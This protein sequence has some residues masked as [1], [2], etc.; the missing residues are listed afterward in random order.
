MTDLHDVL[1]APE[2]AE[3]LRVH[4]KTVYKLAKDGIIPGKLFGRSWRFSRTEILAFVGKGM[5]ESTP[6]RDGRGV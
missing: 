6:N 3:L 1:I 4:V 2:V 5:G